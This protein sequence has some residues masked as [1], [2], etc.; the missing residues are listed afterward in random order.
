I[1]YS[2][3]DI[4]PQYTA[5][6]NYTSNVY[7]LADANPLPTVTGTPGCTFTISPASGVINPTTGEID[8]N[9]SGAG[10]YTIYYNTSAAGNP[11]PVT[12]SVT[13]TLLPQ[14]F[15]APDTIANFCLGDSTALTAAASGNG[16]ITWYSDA[17][18]SRILV[19][20][21]PFFPPVT[22]AGTYTYYVNETGTCPSP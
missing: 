5:T 3:K 21:S 20:G 11:C 9:A 8:I 12:D 13:V 15:I 6:F 14:N 17:A 16:T 10:S 2:T 19:R 4:L 1:N 18:G 22:A 7:C